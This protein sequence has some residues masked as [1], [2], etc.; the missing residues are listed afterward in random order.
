MNKTELKNR[1]QK[2]LDFFSNDISSIRTGRAHPSLIDGL[3]LTAYGSKMTLKELGNITL[4]D[5][6]TLSVSPWDKSLVP[7]IAKALKESDLNL[8]PSED[9]ST[10][11]VPIPPLT[12]ERRQELTKLVNLK[13]EE[14]R[15]SIRS[16]RQEFM[17]IIEKEYT[18]KIISEDEK[19]TYKD[20]IEE[21]VKDYSKQIEEIAKKKNSDLMEI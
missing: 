10:I 1:L 9:A 8:N 20:E 13:A 3:T 14:S 7:T 6:Q 2:S 11:I 5:S 12:Q 4:L 16:I 19:F 21:I 15:Q 18:D 17:K